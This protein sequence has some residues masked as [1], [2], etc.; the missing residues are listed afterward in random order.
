MITRAECCKQIKKPIHWLEAIEKEF[1]I[2]LISQEDG[3]YSV[4]ELLKLQRLDKER[5][6]SAINLNEV[7]WNQY[8]DS[9][10]KLWLSELKKSCFEIGV[11]E[12]KFEKIYSYVDSKINNPDDFFKEISELW[13]VFK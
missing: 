12:E 10:D 2:Q 5:Y 9:V 1:S 11:P 6:D 13:E 7:L 3:T 4:D 8:G